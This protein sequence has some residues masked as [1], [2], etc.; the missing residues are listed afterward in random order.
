MEHV[1]GNFLRFAYAFVFVPASCAFTHSYF[2]CRCVFLPLIS[3]HEGE[4]RQ[5]PFLWL[6]SVLYF[7]LVWPLRH[8]HVCLLCL[9]RGWLVDWRLDVLLLLL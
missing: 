8:F 2:I 7:I 1:S 3:G 6:A 9:S 4:E 5:A